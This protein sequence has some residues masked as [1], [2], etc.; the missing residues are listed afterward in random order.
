MTWIWVSLWL[1]PHGSVISRSL[2]S[3]SII[4]MAPPSTNPTLGL[5][6]LL[7]SKDL[8]FSFSPSSH[9]YSVV[10]VYGAKGSL[11]GGGSYIRFVLFYGLLVHRVFCSCFL[12]YPRSQTSFVAMLTNYVAHLL[13]VEF[14]I[15][16]C[17]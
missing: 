11:T 4:S 16:L 17:I 14:V 6:L 15:T 8:F 3:P 2:A 10:S 13:L 12:C 9:H 1:C 7:P 5:F